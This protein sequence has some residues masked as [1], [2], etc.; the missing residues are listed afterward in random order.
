MNREDAKEELNKAFKK[1]KCR[2]IDN[3]RCKCQSNPFGLEE[4]I[5]K[6]YDNFESMTCENC[7]FKIKN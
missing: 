4:V 6:I 7:I 5:N 2:C 1:Y 3:G